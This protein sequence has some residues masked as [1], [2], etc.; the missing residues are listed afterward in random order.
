MAVRTSEG[1][2]LEILEST[3]ALDVPIEVDLFD[4]ANP[5]TMLATLEGAFGKR[6][7]RELSELG[8]G[9]FRLPLSDP[10]ATDANLAVGNLVRFRVAGTHRHAIWIEEPARTVVSE[11]EEEGEVAA[12]DGRGALAYLERAAA[13]PPVWPP[14]PGA[15]VG[16]STADNGAGA[17]SLSVAKP[18][19]SGRGDVAIAKILC[20]GANPATPRGW[21]RI[22]VQTN[23]TLRLVIYRRRILSA[24]PGSWTWHWTA[25]TKATGVVVSLRNAS[26]DDSTW[27]ISDTSGTG[28]AITEPSVSVGLVDGVLVGIAASAANTAITEP[29]SL[30]EV[31]D[32]QASGRTLEVAY[33]ENPA[34]GDTGDLVA[35][36]GAL[37]DWIGMQVF[38]PSTA[39]ADV[40]FAGATFGTVLSTLIDEAQARGAVPHL[41]YDFT[42]DV[43]SHGEPWPDTHDLSF[44]IGTNLLEVWRHLVT[45]GLEG[46]MT[47]ELRL[48]AYVDAS[49]RF[50]DRVILRKGHHF[51]GDVT[52]T[53]HGSGLRTHELVEGAGGRVVEVGDPVAA[54]VPRIGRR[55]GY[56]ALTTSDD[57]TTLQRA[58][59]WALE[60]TA[61]EDEARAIRVEHGTA[62]EGHYEPWVDYREGDWIGLDARGSGGAPEAQRV[63]SITL[64]ETDAGDYAVELELNSTELD[65]FLRLQ[66]RMDAL[67]RQ[68]TASGGGGGAGGGGTTSTGRVASVSTDSPGYLFDK[69]D[70]GPGIRKALTG[71]T[72]SQRV[73]ISSTITPSDAVTAEQAYGQAPA[74]GTA[75]SASRGDHTHGTPPLAS[76]TPTASAVGDAGSVGAGSTPA[77]A[78]HRH[79]REGFGGAGAAHVGT[80]GS[81]GVG[82]TVARGDHAHPAVLERGG[83]GAN[84]TLFG[85]TDHAT[86]GTLR[87]LRGFLKWIGA[88]GYHGAIAFL[89]G[90]GAGVELLSPPDGTSGDAASTLTALAVGG[91]GQPFIEAGGGFRRAGMDA[92]HEDDLADSVNAAAW[93]DVAAAG[94]SGLPS[95]ADHDHGLP[96]NQVDLQNVLTPA[97]PAPGLTRI[98]VDGSDGHVKRR[99]SSGTVVDLEAGGGGG[100][101]SV[102]TDT[103][104]DAKGDL[105]AGTGSDAASRLPVGSNGQVLTADDSTATGLK[106]APAGG[107][108]GDPLDDVTLDATYGDHFTGTTLDA[109]WTRRSRQTGHGEIFSGT[110]MKILPTNAGNF[111][112]TQAFTDAAEFDVEMACSILDPTDDGFGILVVNSSGTGIWLGHR[113][114]NR[115]GFFT[116][117]TFATALEPVAGQN[118]SLAGSTLVANGR[119]TWLRVEKRKCLGTDT[120]FFRFSLDGASWS[121]P[122]VGYQPSAFTPQLIGW[123]AG[124]QAAGASPVWRQPALDWFNARTRSVGNNLCTAPSSGTLTWTTDATSP[125]G[126]PANISNGSIAD[127]NLFPSSNSAGVSYTGTWSVAQTINR[128]RIRFR[129][130]AWGSGYVETSDGTRTA[131]HGFAGGWCNVDLPA[132]VS[133]TYVKIVWTK[134][135][136]G[137]NPGINEV[138]AYLAS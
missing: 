129:G 130:D 78:D 35:T 1:K 92:L 50:E 136:H 65:A 16:S 84:E 110:W 12:I 83:A 60:A 100:G 131:F 56:L 45:L 2:F 20:V 123:W 6:F 73:R 71:E 42:G 47:P 115:M 64:E 66:R 68:S 33:A 36:A 127:E 14:A 53:S 26:S 82:T 93:G 43:D 85:L 67:S 111:G 37:A 39:S 9:G 75:S 87:R 117:T 119:K 80:A 24:E 28:T 11:R 69:I 120:Y 104:W 121:I 17:T 31:R 90:S 99:S 19:G 23:G 91:S 62:A 81:A 30:T 126:T 21:K 96:N 98:Y 3:P 7:M 48:Q 108:G 10:K 102:A 118:L 86:P 89:N 22:R 97:S 15:F 55:E 132:A 49:R 101:G 77:R 134:H 40:V 135:L 106:W 124:V 32:N 76:T 18:T 63:V 112:D 94:T 29:P 51:T 138:E 59:E 38:V 114:S 125:T 27:G 88:T 57:P 8:S 107:G 44:H 95:R 109:K 137:A 116:V 74:A 122:L 41:T 103:I 54:A 58:G 34:L 25:P 4:G 70:A 52:D 46:G 61:R 105:A 5:A 13:Y 133:T 79:G 72:G 113:A 128:V